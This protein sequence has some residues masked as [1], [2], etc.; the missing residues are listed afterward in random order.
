MAS[1]SSADS[2]LVLYYSQNGTTKA[3]AEE[4]QK[5]LGCDIA[6]IEAVQP[7]DGDYP[8]TISRWQQELADSVRPELKPLDVNIDDYTTVFLGFPI[9]G[10]TYALPMATFLDGNSLEGKRIVTFATFGSGGIENATAAIAG[11]HPGAE[12]IEGYGVR[13]ARIGKAPEE[14]ARF[15]IGKGFIEGE[16]EN[17]PDYSAPEAV[18][19]AD[20]EIF[21]NACGSYQFPLGTPV[22]VGSRATSAGTDYRFEVS[23]PAPDGKLSDG[24]IYVTVPT[25]ATPE[26]T[27]VVRP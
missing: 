19:D 2:I 9:W 12:V 20:K 13:N 5:L 10:G 7:Y 11:S 14:I 24:I 1:N 4:F 27:R 15:L 6:A 22:K 21:D 26:F 16:I 23:V 18:T 8:A 17:Y 25:G 3:V